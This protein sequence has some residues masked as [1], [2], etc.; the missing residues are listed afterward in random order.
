[1]STTEKQKGDWEQAIRKT[2]V[3]F[4]LRL[5]K[6][7]HLKRI[8]E[9]NKASI[10]KSTVCPFVRYWYSNFIFNLTANCANERSKWLF[11]IN[12]FLWIGNDFPQSHTKVVFKRTFHHITQNTFLL[13]LM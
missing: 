13:C 9:C 4:K 3:G 10:Q 5:A 8:I 2:H 12:E 11:I 7:K 6:K 1:M